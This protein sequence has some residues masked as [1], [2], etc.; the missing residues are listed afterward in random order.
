M[1]YPRK[2]RRRCIGEGLTL[3]SLLRR[4]YLEL[5]DDRWVGHGER[6][7]HGTTARDGVQSL[8]LRLVD[9]AGQH[10]VLLDQIDLAVRTCL[11]SGALGGGHS[12]VA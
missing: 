5:L 8:T 12:L 9:V 7:V 2:P 1:G 11:A 6:L 10:D 3:Q 4:S